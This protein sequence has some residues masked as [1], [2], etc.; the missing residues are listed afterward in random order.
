[1]HCHESATFLSHAR[2]TGVIISPT[3]IVFKLIVS[4]NEKI[5]HKMHVVVQS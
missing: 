3:R 4:V 1:M 5:L 2:K